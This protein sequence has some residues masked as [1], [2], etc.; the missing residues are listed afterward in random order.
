M[1][2]EHRL[3]DEQPNA[4]NG[5]PLPRLSA[6]FI[7]LISQ[8]STWHGVR[9]AWETRASFVINFNQ[10]LELIYSYNY[11]PIFAVKMPLSI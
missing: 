3:S 2:V 9:W 10:Y 1:A 5:F 4:L 6:L 11:N 7:F 8:G